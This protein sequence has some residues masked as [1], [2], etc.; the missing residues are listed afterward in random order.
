MNIHI[1]NKEIWFE[2]NPE[3][4]EQLF[5]SINKYLQKDDLQF[6]HLIIDEEVIY[7][8]FDNYIIE[9]IESINKIEVIAITLTEMVNESLKSAEQ[10]SKNAITIINKTAEEFYQ[11]PDENTWSQLTDLFEGIQWI[12]QSL[13]EINSI[14]SSYEVVSDYE[15]WNDYIQEV[16]KFNSIIFEL[17]NAVLN[18]DNVLIGDMLLHEIIPIF[19][20]MV[21]KLE[22][23]I[24]EAVDKDVNW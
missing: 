17:E 10:Y 22:L 21:E 4:I 13:T 5:N 18:K 16:S 24:S 6:S 7:D 8:N 11:K 14:E 2:N 15:I 23:L 1:Q 3:I 20:A 12:I 19:E 9:N